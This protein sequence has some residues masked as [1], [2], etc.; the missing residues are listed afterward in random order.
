LDLA[1][2]AGVLDDIGTLPTFETVAAAVDW[3]KTQ[4]TGT[5]TTDG[6]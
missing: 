6:A 2:R 4:T 3:A 5:A 1:R